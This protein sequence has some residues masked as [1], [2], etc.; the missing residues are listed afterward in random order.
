MPELTSDRTHHGTCIHARCGHCCILS[1]DACLAEEGISF[2]LDGCV[3]IDCR[4]GRF[5]LRDVTPTARYC[6]DCA[7]RKARGCGGG[8][9]T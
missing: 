2:R 5:C 7:R 9:A 4:L 8:V 6:S 1:L 3:Y